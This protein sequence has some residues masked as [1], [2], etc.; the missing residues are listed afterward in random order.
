MALRAPYLRAGNSHI[1][2]L[3]ASSE[4]IGL[5][6]F[7]IAWYCLGLNFAYDERNLGLFH[8]KFT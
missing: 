4:S 6:D 8:R 1:T 7:G 3:R 2:T 5:G